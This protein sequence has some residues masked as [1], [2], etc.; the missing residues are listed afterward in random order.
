MND[1]K[2]TCPH[3]KLCGGCAYQGIGYK[4]QLEVKQQREAA[5]LSSFCKISPIMGA[6]NPY[7]YR[8]KVH[9][10]FARQKNGNV[11]AGSYVANTHRI[12]DTA[13]CLIEDGRAGEIINTVKKLAVDFKL[14]IYD[15]DRHTGV[16]RHML[17]RSGYDTGEYLVV[18]VIGTPVFPSK[19]N[20][21]RELVRLC[22]YITSVVVNINDRNTSMILG[23]RQSVEYGRG[24]INDRLCGLEYR[25]SPQSFYQVNPAQTEKLYNT[26]IELAGLTGSETVLDAYCGIGTIG[27]TAS[28]HCRRVISVES[29]KAAIADAKLNLKSNGITNVELHADDAGRYMTRL[30]RSNEGLDVVFMDPPRSGSDK[31]FL[32]SLLTLKPKK[33]IY[34]SC[35]PETLARDLRV[36]TSRFYKV[37]KIQ[38]VDMFP[39]TEGI[40]T[41]ADIERV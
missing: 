11:I 19:K 8:N 23:E 3:G 28:R 12:L 27:M 37:K 10:A 36:L 26:A 35:N 41:V 34:V 18:L 6:E 1:N 21:I 17:V 40:E 15:E 16:L 24:Y 25:I 29:N 9:A 5:L 22:P 20:F 13:G 4:K 39:W 7:H 31:A 38:P 2:K 33:I 30:A 14:K 32:N